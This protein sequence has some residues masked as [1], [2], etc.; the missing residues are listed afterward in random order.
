MLITAENKMGA[1]RRISQNY[2][3]RLLGTTSFR[4]EDREWLQNNLNATRTFLQKLGPDDEIDHARYIWRRVDWKLIYDFLSQYATDPRSSSI[5]ATSVRQYIYAQTQQGEL[6]NWTVAVVSQNNQAL[7][8]ENL[9]IEGHPSVYTIGRTRK[10]IQQHSIGALINPATSSGSPGAGDEEVGLS[11]DQVRSARTNV[12][13]GTYATF[14]DALRAERDKTEGLLL[15]YPVSKL[16]KPAG[17]SNFRIPL[18]DNPERD[19]CTVIGVALAFPR[20]SSAATI[21]YVT[22][23]VGD[24]GSVES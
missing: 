18:F 7:D 6:I 14:G 17:E 3:G 11:D 15:I 9:F 21:E 12:T 19:G 16:S 13:D 20:S 23:S 1:G 22:G 10:V 2:G 5:N 4:L 8:T 24:L